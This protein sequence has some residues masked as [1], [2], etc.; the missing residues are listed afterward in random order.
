MTCGTEPTPSIWDPEWKGRPDPVITGVEPPGGTFAGIGIVTL[1]GENFSSEPAENHVYF[2][3][4]KGEI[5]SAT[6]TAVQV[7]APNLTGD[8]VRIKLRGGRC[9]PVCR[10]VSVQT[11]TSR[12][13]MGRFR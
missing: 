7:K 10:V 3:G 1:I 12:H 11:G 13:R 6:P 4:V 5:L 8:S 9:D 2:D